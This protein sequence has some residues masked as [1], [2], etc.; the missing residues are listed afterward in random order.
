L[1][2]SPYRI[3]SPIRILIRA[4]SP[5]SLENIRDLLAS[6][7][8]FSIVRDPAHADVTLFDLTEDGDGPLP[9]DALHGRIL[10]LLPAT[11]SQSL[12]A[13]ALSSDASVL[14]DEASRDQVVQAVRSVAS[15]LRVQPR[16]A[17]SVSLSLPMHPPP[18]LVE[19]SDVLTPREREILR[20][21]GEGLPNHAI[22][23]RL[24]LSDHTVK[25]HLKAVFAKLGARSRTEAVSLA[26]RK[27]MLLL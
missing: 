19:T 27:G 9:L 22:A 8:A 1:G 16:L 10:I 21:L 20:L 12:L 23:G 13:D 17:A 4:R 25:F 14:T 2:L 3:M 7:R 24:G 11:V 6:E 5:R 18:S 15:G 26:V